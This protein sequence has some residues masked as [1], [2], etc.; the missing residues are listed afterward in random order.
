MCRSSVKPSVAAVRLQV[1]TC[2]LPTLYDHLPH[3]GEFNIVS[4]PSLR[5][6]PGS[7]IHSQ[8][9]SLF[10]QDFEI[11]ILHHWPA[12]KFLVGLN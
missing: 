4:M 1:P 5:D 8:W 12:A 3:E 7:P 11:R 6:I 10:G 9:V 2:L